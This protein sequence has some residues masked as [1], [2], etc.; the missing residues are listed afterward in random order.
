MVD[1]S[2]VG[3]PGLLELIEEELISVA[4]VG[5]VAIVEQF[6]DLG[7]RLD[8]GVLTLACS[9]TE[10]CLDL[11]RIGSE[12]ERPL[13]RD[14]GSQVREFDLGAEVRRSIVMASRSMLA[15]ARQY[16]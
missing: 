3:S 4:E 16:T 2:G 9:V 8:V 13:E 10:D 7:K 11:T 5:A 12:P 15:K 14:L 6:D 1:K